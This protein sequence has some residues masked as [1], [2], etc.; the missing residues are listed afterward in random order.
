METKRAF[1]KFFEE[2]IPQAI[3]LDSVFGEQLMDV[4]N[5]ENF[6]LLH[7]K[8]TVKTL[9][10][11]YFSHK[12]FPSLALLE[13][14]FTKD[15][16]DET[17]KKRCL[18]YL[19]KMKT[20]PL[21]GDLDYVKEKSLE[22]FRLQNIANCL[23]KEVLPKIEEG[24][25]IEDIV[26]IIQRAVSRGTSNNFGY[27]YHEDEELRFI[28]KKEN[29]ISSGWKYLNELL[30][31]GYGEGR[32]VTFIGPAGAGKS[33]LLVGSGV[34]ALLQGRTVVHYTLELDE[35]DVARKYDACLTDIEINSIT[36]SK[37]KVLSTLKQKL[38]ADAKLII[39]EYPM[40]SASIQ[41]IQSHLSRL[42]L[43]GI[44][45]HVVI[46]DYGD[47]LRNVETSFREEKRNGLEAIWQDMKALAQT[48]KIPVVTATQTNRTGYGAD[49][50]MPDQ[51]SEDFSKIMTADIIITLARNMQQKIA[52]MG[53]M[54]LAKNRQGKDGIIY[55]YSIDT[56]RCQIKMFELTPDLESQMN[57]EERQKTENIQDK[58]NK[59]LQS[60]RR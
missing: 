43:K 5:E 52:G 58:V 25:N 26:S 60:Q 32:L 24:K 11:F 46:I 40:K 41:T 9:K 57:P 4:L 47:L 56:T 19:S 23:E 15:I 59:F 31:G 10:E 3:L 18:D 21:N 1:D 45:P 28:D 2:K 14:I 20:S 54:Y 35:L 49:I 48:L 39:K 33:S 27:E 37:S 36:G 34:G 38:P 42:K 7:T 16:S 22:F 51:V 30:G 6:C 50:I 55:A 13:S 8:E 29:F 53:K 17:L 44:T 12:S